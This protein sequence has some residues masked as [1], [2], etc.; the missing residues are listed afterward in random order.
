MT[1]AEIAQ[2]IRAGVQSSAFADS[3]KFDCGDDGVLV[4]GGGDV[5]LEDRETDV[6]LKMSVE[7]VEKLIK[8]KL[9]PMTALMM[10]KIKLSG[11]PAV[12]MKLKDL[13]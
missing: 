9:N 13:L 8:G 1:L 10:G 12:A 6:T 3:L 5:S 4:I 7:N 2:M 11:N